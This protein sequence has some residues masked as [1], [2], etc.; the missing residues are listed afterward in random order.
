MIY[1][2]NAI[3][4]RVLE[5]SKF[6]TEK[7]KKILERTIEEARFIIYYDATL[8]ETAEHFGKV[9]KSTVQIDVS[10][11]LWHY[12]PELAKEVNKVLTVN[13]DESL[14]RANAARRKKIKV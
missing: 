6:M 2:E 1:N 10:V 14:M 7:E 11:R 3:R 8:R 5:L 4:A 12:F 13:A 9:T